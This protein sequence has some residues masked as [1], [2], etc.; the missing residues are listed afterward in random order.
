MMHILQKRYPN[1]IFAQR[2]ANF[3]KDAFGELK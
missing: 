1:H 3:K 2:S